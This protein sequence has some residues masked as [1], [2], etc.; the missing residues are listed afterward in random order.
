[1]LF[2]FRR[3]L[4]NSKSV[5]VDNT[6]LNGP[7]K[8]KNWDML[9]ADLKEC[10]GGAR[11]IFYDREPFFELLVRMGGVQHELSIFDPHKEVTKH[12]L[13][14]AITEETEILSQTDEIFECKPL[15]PMIVDFMEEECTTEE[16]NT[17]R[18]AVISY[19]ENLK[20]EFE[21]TVDLQIVD[22]NS[23]GL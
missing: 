4:K 20:N 8:S 1:M 23:S 16:F 9:A 6:C 3:V 2:E 5:L 12:T 14:C 19:L 17:K 11:L 18:A 13:I 22:C 21:K 10:D 7:N 15:L